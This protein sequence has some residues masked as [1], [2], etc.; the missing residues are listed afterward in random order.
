[1]LHYMDGEIQ[2][3]VVTSLL[4][5]YSFYFIRYKEGIVIPKEPI[6]KIVSLSCPFSVGGTTRLPGAV[7]TVNEEIRA[8]CSLVCDVRSDCEGKR[9]VQ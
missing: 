5:P 6:V 7:A 1:M 3:S 9:T 2:L 4:R 8:L